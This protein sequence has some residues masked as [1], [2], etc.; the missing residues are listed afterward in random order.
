MKQKREPAE[1]LWASVPPR[2]HRLVEEAAAQQFLTTGEFVKRA[3]IA[4]LEQ[5]RE[6]ADG[7]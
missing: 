7:R 5:Q 1:R 3:V 4:A 6:V 2:L